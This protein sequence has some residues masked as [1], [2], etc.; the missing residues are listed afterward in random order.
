MSASIIRNISLFL[1]ACCASLRKRALSKIII[2]QIYSSFLIISFRCV[3]VRGLTNYGTV[4]SLH[5]L[6]VIC[7]SYQDIQWFSCAIT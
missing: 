3:D 5:D 2:V 4:L 1:F 7:R 6:L